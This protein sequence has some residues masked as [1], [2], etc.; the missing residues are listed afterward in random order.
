[1][2]IRLAVNYEV[3]GSALITAA[4][5]KSDLAKITAHRF[6]STAQ[7][8]L[9]LTGPPESEAKDSKPGQR[10][11]DITDPV[12]ATLE[13]E[14]LIPEPAGSGLGKPLLDLKQLLEVISLPGGN[15]L[16]PKGTST[17]PNT[18]DPRMKGQLV[19]AGTGRRFEINVDL[20]FLDVTDYY[21]TL[22]GRLDEYTNLPQNDTSKP[23]HY[24]ARLRIFECTLGKPVCWA[25]LIPPAVKP[26]SQQVGAVLFFRPTSK[27]DYT[28]TDDLGAVPLS[29]KP[30]FLTAIGEMNRYLGD[31]QPAATPFFAQ[32]FPTGWNRYPNCGW[33]RQLSAANKCALLVLPFPHGYDFGTIIVS[34]GVSRFPELLDSIRKALWSDRTIGQS[35]CADL[36]LARIAVSGFSSAGF[37]TY[38]CLPPKPKGRPEKID[39]MYLFDPIG[40]D[41]NK[42]A[43]E[44]WFRLGGKKLRMFG[45]AYQLDTMLAIAKDLASSDASVLPAGRDGWG[46]LS[47]LYPLAVHLPSFPTF[48]APT[49]TTLGM[50]STLTSMFVVGADGNGGLNMEGH[51]S[52]KVEK[53]VINNC[54]AE[55]AATMTLTMIIAQN[56]GKI[57]TV[58]KG[59]QLVNAQLVQTGTGDDKFNVRTAAAFHQNLN[60]ISLMI[61]D[62]RHQWPVVGGFDSSG[63][64]IVGNGFTGF[65]QT[66]LSSSG[67]P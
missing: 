13:L 36:S 10:R 51:F 17:C 11:W 18:F 4:Q 50:L 44:A 57:L 46:I 41:T 27:R 7:V 64:R 35:V 5:N 58:Q 2:A 39:E 54:I 60:A 59:G 3:P 67:F 42:A 14:I 23:K 37:W 21:Q 20:T 31:P 30:P 47:S 9:T 19:G 45:G 40:T 6:V 25:V 29:V 53:G 63:T 12:G 48:N 56:K 38:A 62:V 15:S 8:T 33:E 43:I 61:V 66:A 49:D 24:G 28:N 34:Q 1:M 65:L 22:T 55:E 32:P 26:D 16:S 52:G